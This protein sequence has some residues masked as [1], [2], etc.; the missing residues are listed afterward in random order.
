MLR[1]GPESP[2][3]F[4][5]P[6]AG[7]TLLPKAT[8]QEGPFMSNAM[9]QASIHVFNHSLTALAAVLD[10]A[11]AH[12]AAKK[13]DPAVMLASRLIADMFPLT[14]QVQI[15]CDF[16]KG[17]AAR[18]AGKE[19]PSW[20]DD[21]KSFADL[22]ARIAKTIDFVAA[23]QP[24]EVDGS[25]KRPMQGIKMRG[26]PVK[27][28]GLNYLH[29]FCLPNLYFHITTAYAILRANGVDLGKGDFMGAVPGL[30]MGA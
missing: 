30:T 23:V 14:R 4:F 28:D 19:V 24:A 1:S 16:A 17:G 5:C 21:E 22:K 7:A 11:E 29:H 15:A 3:A 9:Y 26:Q 13:I 12:C 18:L 27:I 10:K 25:D 20:P 8:A 2:A 6:A